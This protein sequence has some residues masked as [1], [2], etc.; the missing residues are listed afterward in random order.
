MFKIDR[1]ICYALY[2]LNYFV[3]REK[4][5]KASA[6]EIS[7]LHQTPFDATSR[8]MQQMAQQGWLDSARGVGGGYSLQADLKTI[9]FLELSEA[10]LGVN[11]TGKCLRAKLTECDS[12]DDCDVLDPAAKL[13][14]RVETLFAETP[15]S[16]LVVIDGVL[17][18]NDNLVKLE[19]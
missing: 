15:L 3:N 19:I 4:G 17:Q 2:V 7:E 13:T 1:K 14:Q 18:C 11:P 6:R 5:Y 12:A 8:T 9:S 16:E 10:I